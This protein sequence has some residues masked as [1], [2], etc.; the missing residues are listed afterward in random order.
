MSDLPKLTEKAILNYVGE[1]S[2]RLGREYVADD[3]LFDTRL[4][5][6]SIRAR[7][8]GNSGGPYRVSATLTPSGITSDCSCPV[9]DGG[10]CK[11]VGA[12]LLAWMKDPGQFTAVE[13]L[14]QALNNRSKEELVAILRQ[15]FRRHPD[16]E[17]LLETPLP[18]AGKKRVKPVKPE[19]YQRQSAAVFSKAGDGY[20]GWG[21][22]EDELA[23]IV[24]IGNDF[25]AQE[26]WEG[27]A[28]V[29]RG[30]LDTLLDVYNDYDDGSGSLDQMVADCVHNL[31]RCLIAAGDDW[32]LREPMLRALFDVY[33]TDIRRGGVGL[34]DEAVEVL[35]ERTSPDE[36]RHLA[37]WIRKELPKVERG[38]ASEALGGFLMDLEQDSMDDETNLRLCRDTGRTDDLV[39]RLLKLGRVEEATKELDKAK[40]HELVSLAE[41]FVT[42]GHGD[43]AEPILAIR[44][45]KAKDGRI[46]DWLRR[47]YASRN[48]GAGELEM[49]GRMF[50]SYPTVDG[51]R[52]LRARAIALG[53]W[54]AIEKI[55]KNTLKTNR[56]NDLLIRIALDEGDVDAALRLMESGNVHGASME[57][58]AAAENVRPGAALKIYRKA[59]EDFIAHRTRGSY[60]EACKHLKKVQTMYAKMG[61]P[62]GWEQYINK[63]RQKNHA[64]RALM[65]ELAAAQL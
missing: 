55:L 20:A 56:R 42:Q 5:G 46:F 37:D 43:V 31:D 2:V 18:T 64:L 49:A 28:A 10:Q 4:Q 39:D 32:A 51:Y 12:L 48:D 35:D 63:I 26:D 7:C 58:A 47:R 3:S 17:S 36:R 23:A 13:E 24:E 50:D 60:Q 61:E 44:A 27:A 11:H 33:L 52:E 1:R 14:D 16:L 34:S 62:D 29:S 30:M 25:V 15:V 21:D 53:Q 59:A 22:I 57:V 8:H 40:D 6:K 38:W 9:G 45:K 41:R 54:E 19:T 65:E